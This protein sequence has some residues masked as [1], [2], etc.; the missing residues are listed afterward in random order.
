MTPR[1]PWLAA[2]L[3]VA[4]ASGLALASDFLDPTGS[5]A[6]RLL[7]G[8][9][10]VAAL[11]W[12]AIHH[13]SP[14]RGA[15]LLMALGFGFT[16]VGDAIYDSLNARDVPETSGW[17]DVVSVLYMGMYPVIF[18]ALIRIVNGS[19]QKFHFDNVVDS[20]IGFLVAILLVQ[21]IFISPNM[22][23]A[24]TDW[25][26]VGY[27][28]G[29]AM[30]LSAVGWLAFTRS[31]RNPGVWLVAIGLALLVAADAAWELGAQPGFA[32]L[33]LLVDPIYPISY[34]VIGAA[35]LLPA[36]AHIGE[37]EADRIDLHGARLVFLCGS[38]ALIPIAAFIGAGDQAIVRVSISVLVAAVALRFAALTRT[39]QNANRAAEASSTRFAN[40]ASAAPV[41]IFECSA[42][43]TIVFAN[44]AAERFLGMSPVGKSA[45][46]LITGFVD[47]RDQPILFDAVKTILNGAATSTQLR[48]RNLSGAQRW[49]VW[50]AV[51]I[52][53]GPNGFSGAF[54]SIIDI[55]AIKDAEQML[56]LQATHDALTGLPNRR[57]L[58]DRLSSAVRRLDRM[59]G[60]LAVLF[61]D[62][63]GFKLV[64]DRYGHD[65][66]DELLNLVA[67]RLLHTVRAADTVARLGGD[68]FVI[69]LEHISDSANAVAI[70]NNILRSIREPAELADAVVTVSASIGIA[71]SSD[72]HADPDGLLHDADTAMYAAKRAG[73]GIAHTFGDPTSQLQLEPAPGV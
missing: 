23:G 46:E 66:G 59:P 57:M 41:A 3:L 60:Q 48:L 70:A 73:P 36:A 68:E 63:D 67:T 5:I 20:A 8:L 61:L 51:P 30:L 11:V 35:V 65:A 4:T 55:T 71:I 17:Y 6:A 58:L 13:G 69:I 54:V 14:S 7:A 33:S 26:G 44:E 29:D 32:S 2:V 24:S 15:W 50:S 42:D 25:F 28:F 39:V 9:L 19:F 43:L 72:P 27:L 52:L 10:T 47:D 18:V 37:T 31:R 64:N 21:L 38:L 40:L 53:S 12:G 62:L 45:N 1:A 22:K 56:T 49:V 34:A 16:I